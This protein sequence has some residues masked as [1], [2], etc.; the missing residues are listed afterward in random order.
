[1]EI[2][3]ME[4]LPGACNVKDLTSI[5]SHQKIAEL[6]ESIQQ[7]AERE[8]EINGKLCEMEECLKEKDEN[9]RSLEE[10]CKKLAYQ[11][12]ELHDTFAEQEKCLKEAEVSYIYI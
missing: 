3:A 11:L 10:K 8:M 7:Y 4:K 5:D 6:E 9:I 1:M 12:A 2:K